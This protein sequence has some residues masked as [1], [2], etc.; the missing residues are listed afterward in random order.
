M[1]NGGNCDNRLTIR[2]DVL[3]ETVVRGLKDNLLQPQLI[4]EF[5][6]T[7]Q[8]EY[9]RF[10]RVHANEHAE[11]ARVERQIRNIVEAVKAS[12][13]APT[14]KDEM[15]ALEERKARLVGSMRNQVEEPPMLHSG[16]A[17][18]YRRKVEKLTHALNKEDLR[19]R[20]GRDAA[21]DDPGDPARA[22]ERGAGGRIG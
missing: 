1:R 13:F 21:L 10:Q 18:V 17:E 8:L 6:A 2:R 3:E 9:N 20:G 16:L 15:A 22:G 7:Y 19:A 4:H 5:V 11:L 14:I 12:L